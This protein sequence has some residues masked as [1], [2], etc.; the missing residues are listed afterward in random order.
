[1]YYVCYNLDNGYIYFNNEV[2][3]YSFLDDNYSHYDYYYYYCNDYDDDYNYYYRNFDDDN[4]YSDYSNFVDDDYNK[5]VYFKKPLNYF[6]RL[7]LVK[8]NIVNS[9]NNNDDYNQSITLII[10]NCKTY[11]L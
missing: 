4:N 2:N 10:N 9:S 1:M 7:V 3:G 8:N 6:E 11:I 5:L